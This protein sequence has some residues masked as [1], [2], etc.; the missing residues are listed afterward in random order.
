MGK[1]VLLAEIASRAGERYGW[2]TLAVEAP[3]SGQ[4][5]PT[6]VGRAE[7]VRALLG[8]E[9]PGAHLR[10]TGAVVRATIPGIGG[11]LHLSKEPG[12]QGRPL[13]S[14]E[15]VLGFLMDEAIEHSTGVVL[16]LDEAH[17]AHRE[18]LGALGAAIQQGTGANWPM[19]VVIAGLPSLRAGRLPSYFERADWHEVRSLP[20]EAALD[21]LVAP[22]Q[23]AGRPFEEG[24]GERLARETGGYP[25]AVQLY[26]HAAWRASQGQT[27]ITM[28]ALD[29]AIP[30]AKATLERNLFAQ[31]W[32]QASPRE[33]QYLVALA[34]QMVAGGP[35]T[36]AGVAERLG[37]TTRA[38]AQYRERLISKG[39][40]V[41]E[42][43]R[44]SFVVPGLAEYILGR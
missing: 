13:L 33:R 42:G 39:T 32:E 7:A 28:A 44:L 16:T 43:E 19:V 34:E 35:A 8:E 40:L 20:A 30:A 24:A 12:A 37:M 1:T 11:E 15:R 26:G 17:V 9:P 22:A 27:Q 36:G 41:A 23:A 4:V 31:R 29:E 5:V 2:P 25:Y 10:V 6:L 38:L 14:T 21:A 3:L 18:D